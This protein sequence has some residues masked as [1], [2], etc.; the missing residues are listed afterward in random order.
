MIGHNTNEASFA[1]DWSK[2]SYR[3][4]SGSK[5]LRVLIWDIEDYQQKLTSNYILNS[6]RELSSI[7]VSDNIKIPYMTELK[8]HE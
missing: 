1:L 5:D 6:K 2:T 7:G 4:A 3:V 8:G